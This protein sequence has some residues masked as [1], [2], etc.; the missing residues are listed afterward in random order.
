MRN[1]VSHFRVSGLAAR[2][3][4]TRRS[5]DGKVRGLAAHGITPRITPRVKWGVAARRPGL[6]VPSG[7]D[8]RAT[9]LIADRSHRLP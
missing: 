6:P 9:P 7:P 1:K 2:G 5:P 3:E 4:G 8:T